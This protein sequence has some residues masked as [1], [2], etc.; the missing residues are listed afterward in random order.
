MSQTMSMNPD[1]DDLDKLRDL[2]RP[3]WRHDEYDDEAVQIDRAES[4]EETRLEPEHGVGGSM[5]MPL[6]DIPLLPMHFLASPQPRPPESTVAV[7]NEYEDDDAEK[8][9]CYGEHA[10]FGCSM[11]MPHA[12]MHLVCKW[13][14]A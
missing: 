13:S 8:K 10:K 6:P 7:A 3:G 14:T 12:D 5:C 4:R 1:G 9:E 11:S 2:W